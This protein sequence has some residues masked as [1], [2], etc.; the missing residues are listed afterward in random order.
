MTKYIP[1]STPPIR[2]NQLIRSANAD[3]VRLYSPVTSWGNML[4]MA[5][6]FPNLRGLWPLSNLDNATN[7][8]DYSGQSRILSPSV[9]APTL[10]F[11]GLLPYLNFIRVSSQCMFRNDEAGL[12]ILTS[13]YALSWCYFDTESTGNNTGIMSKYYETGSQV[14]W[15]LYKNSSNNFVFSVS[16]DGTAIAIKSVNDGGANYAISKWF[17][18][19]GIFD[20]STSIKLFVN[21]NWYTN[22]TSIPAAI[23]NSSEALRLGSYNRTNYIDGRMSTSLLGAADGIETIIEAFYAHTKALYGVK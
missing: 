3:Y 10:A 16:T 6:L 2:N 13:L 15:V 5:M 14:S 22:T 18:V 19:A 12:D 7:A 21:G 17:C 11:V 4:S 1:F 9:G 23:H 8:Y 20:P